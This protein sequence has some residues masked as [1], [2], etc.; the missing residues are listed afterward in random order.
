MWDLNEL[1]KDLSREG[2]DFNVA[3]S[4]APPSGWTCVCPLAYTKFA[5]ACFLGPSYSIIS[6]SC[7]PRRWFPDLSPCS[8]S[9]PEN[10]SGESPLKF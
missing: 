4:F 3:A 10:G 9:L 2:W 7:V 6:T 1:E 5:K 8:N